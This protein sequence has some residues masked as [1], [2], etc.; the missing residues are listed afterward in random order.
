MVVYEWDGVAPLINRTSFTHMLD[1]EDRSVAASALIGAYGWVDL[2]RSGRPRIDFIFSAAGTYMDVEFQIDYGTV[3]GGVM[4][5]IDQQVERIS[6]TLDYAPIN[7]NHRLNLDRTRGP[8]VRVRRI[9]NY[10]DGTIQIS[11]RGVSTMRP[12]ESITAV[13]REGL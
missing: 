3:V 2:L 1:G 8:C 13:E 10:G 12:L 5:I 4:E 11:G 6:Q 9:T 7:F